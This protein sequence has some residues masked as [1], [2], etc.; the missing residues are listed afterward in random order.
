MPSNI[1]YPRVDPVAIM[2]I[3]NPAR[4]HVLLGRKKMFPQKMFSCLAGYVEAGKIFLKLNF[5]GK[6]V[7][8]KL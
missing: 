3:V 7:S 6:N 1:H 2:L 5:M 8:L 4:T